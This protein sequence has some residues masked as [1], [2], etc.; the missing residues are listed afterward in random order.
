MTSCDCSTSPDDMS[1]NCTARTVSRCQVGKDLDLSSL[2]FD[3]LS[4]PESFPIP[5]SQFHIQSRIHPLFA[6]PFALRSASEESFVTM[7]RR[8]KRPCLDPGRRSS[9]RTRR[10]T[11][12]VYP[13]FPPF[14]PSSSPPSFLPKL[15]GAHS[16]AGLVRRQSLG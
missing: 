1:C 7:P 5:D 15:Q 2:S 11:L 12:H 4:R 16:A 10:G 14:L 13:P 8:S 9:P 6:L 3:L